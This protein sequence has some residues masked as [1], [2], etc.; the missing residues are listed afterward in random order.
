MM[1]KKNKI[2]KLQVE[3]LSLDNL[4]PKDHLVRK[5][6][7]AINLDFVY[8]LVEDLY[9]NK[10]KESIDPVVLIK[11]NIV[12][13]L[14]G[15]RSMRQT[16]KEIEVNAAY[17][18]YIG[19]GLSEKIP[20]FSTFSKNYTR[21]FEGTNLFEK[22]FKRIIEE[23]IKYGFIDEESIFIDGT[24]IKANANNHK[25]KKSTI[26][27]SV[28]FYEKELSDEINKDR[29]KH[30]KKPLKK[31]GNDVEYK[32]I[33]E[34]TTDSESGVFH[35]GEHK[36]VFA[37]AANVACDKNNY[38]LD[39][40]TTAGN[41]HDSRVFPLIYDKLKNKYE[42]IKNVVLDSGYK[43]P[44]IAKIIIDDGKNPIMPYK[45][46]M[47]KKGYFKKYEYVYDEFYDCYVC[48]N[49]EILKYR[50]TNR[51]GYKEYKS[52][53]NKCKNCIY[54]EKCTGSKKG[55][56]VVIRHVWEEYIE[57]VEDI[58]HKKGS[59]ELYKQRSQTIERIFAD[60]KELHGMRYAK[61]RGLSKMKMELNLLFSCMNLKKLANRLWKDGG[62]S[63]KFCFF[64]FNIMFF[65][66][67]S[68]KTKRLFDFN[69]SKSL[70]SSI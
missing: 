61:Y 21:R 1:G 31:K 55:V 18:W 65:E 46:P 68:K 39:F 13:Y 45:R 4:V 26:E 14:F 62:N 47:T 7:K 44:A 17:R 42:N 57:K 54:L 9:S 15:I 29:L 51:E 60:A 27:K 52:N 59:K 8:E 30:D 22:I 58:R 41:I 23:I 12:Q 34:S 66:K 19:Y 70:L 2:D 33:K 64:I 5:I 36:K 3:I 32:N 43:I 38:I 20:H 56:K 48:P 10:G 24:H 11:I 16:I 28:K 40:E 63:S 35:K 37:Y 25:Y 69:E 67:I 50:T 49:N 6:D 53:P